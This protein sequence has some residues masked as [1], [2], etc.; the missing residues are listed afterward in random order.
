[1]DAK[2][3]EVGEGERVEVRRRAGGGVARDSK[4]ETTEGVTVREDNGGVDGDVVSSEG[5]EARSDFGKEGFDLA[6]SGRDAVFDLDGD[7]REAR[8]LMVHREGDDELLDGRRKSSVDFVVAGF[9][10]E[11]E[12]FELRKVAAGN[13]GPGE[14][15]E[16]E[17]EGSGTCVTSSFPSL[18]PC[19]D[20][21]GLN[22]SALTAPPTFCT[23]VEISAAFNPLTHQICSFSS[24][25]PVV[26]EASQSRRRGET[27]TKSSER[28]VR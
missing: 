12:A 2:V 19:F 23:N 17:E 3:V 26:G 18:L 21:F 6:R 15:V 22:R 9:V 7:G 25:T 27:V 4:L 5:E 20:P 8:V 13:S 1:M 28:E 14:P 16:E 24:A 11:G 10:T